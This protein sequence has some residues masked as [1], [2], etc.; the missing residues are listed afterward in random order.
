[1]E[2]RGNQVR[3]NRIGSYKVVINPGDLGEPEKWCWQCRRWLPTSQFYVKRDRY[4]GLQSECRIC[5]NANVKRSR[6]SPR[7]QKEDGR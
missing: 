3:I 2:A 7:N 5:A 6:K 4:D 1:M